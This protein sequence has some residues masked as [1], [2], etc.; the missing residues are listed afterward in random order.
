M[1]KFDLSALEISGQSLLV[2]LNHMER[3]ATSPFLKKH[4]IPEL[5]EPDQWYPAQNVVDFLWD[6]AGGPNAMY[7]LVSIGMESAKTLVFPPEW[8]HIPLEEFFVNLLPMIYG[9]YFRGGYSGYL[10]TEKV[11]NRYLKVI[12]VTP[13]PDDGW[14]GAIFGLTRRLLPKGTLFNVEYDKVVTRRDHGG[15]ATNI[16]VKWE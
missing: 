12:C 3:D 15:D 13:L 16:F 9:G 10:K 2:Y 1:E 4:H 11:G 14:Y 5:V 7:S 8:D 6:V